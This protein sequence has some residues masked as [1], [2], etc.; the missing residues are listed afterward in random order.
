M[1]ATY[2]APERGVVDVLGGLRMLVAQLRLYPKTSPQV[3]KVGAAATSGLLA[4]LDKNPAMTVAASPEGLLV[5][6]T[7]FP[8]DDPVAISLDASTRALLAEA[9]VKSITFRAGASQEEII[10]FLH[11]LA[12]KFW[13]LRDG[14]KINLKLREE[15]IINVAVDEVEYV[16]L[17]KDDLLLKEAGSKLEA[18]GFDVQELM[19]DLD[20]RLELAI[21]HGKGDEARNGILRKMVEQDP[22]LIAK[23]VKEGVPTPVQADSPGV[24]TQ[25]QALDAVRKIWKS[26][27]TASSEIRESLRGVADTVLSAFKGNV[28]VS[29]ALAK[30]IAGESPE[31]APDWMRE[32]AGMEPEPAAVARARTILFLSPEARAEALNREGKRLIPELVAAG[33]LDLVEQVLGIAG[34]P[35][36]EESS[37]KRMQAAQTLHG[38]HDLFESDALVQGCEALT[39]TLN[40]SLDKEKDAPV[41]AKLVEL[42]ALMVTSKKRKRGAGTGGDDLLETLKRHSASSDPAFP[43]RSSLARAVLPKDLVTITMPSAP[44]S[45][46]AADKVTA[47]LHMASIQFLIAQMKEVENTAERMELAE[48]VARMG[49]NAGVLMVE[50]LKK[51][52]IPSEIIRLLEVLPWVAAQELAEETLTSLLAHPVVLVRRRAALMLVERKHPRTEEILLETFDATPPAGRLG[53]CDAL[54]RLGTEPALTKL[55]QTA[56]SREMPDDLRGACCMA[57]AMAVDPK[58]LQLLTQLATPPARG[59]TRIFRSVTPALRASS[60]RALAAYSQQK[61][62]RDLLEKL[63]GDAEEIVRGAAKEALRPSARFKVPVA[64]TPVAAMAAEAAAQPASPIAAAPPDPKAPVAGFSGLITEMPLDQVCQVIGQSR[65]TGLMLANF[66]GPT[67]KIYFDKGLVVSADFEGKKDQEAFNA[68]FVL[69]EGAFVFKPGERTL[70]P[71]M[72]TTVDQLLMGAFSAAGQGNPPRAGAA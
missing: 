27:A 40:L 53:I 3:A 26:M 2:P 67:A 62:V 57:L 4:F 69:K 1:S 29:A 21:E 66:E 31:L 35:L 43:E 28:T 10:G 7:R 70:E 19:K 49:S 24:L 22:S 25:E 58:S 63:Q 32:L 48:T 5:N 54:G 20:Q 38:W 47:A 56:D 6:G 16:E 65:M 46:S 33:R 39:R 72:K 14:K 60:T 36:Q 30:V 18:A 71:R 23:I 15:R 45:K 50:E 41:Y 12:L 9:A 37:R 59:L 68:F 52:K 17:G 44:L 64:P 55:R 42:A 11:G 34:T 13:E 8:A 51:T 61:E